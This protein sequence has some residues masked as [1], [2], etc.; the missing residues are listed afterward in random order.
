MHNSVVPDLQAIIPS[1][2]SFSCLPSIHKL[3][4]LQ[5][6]N[7]NKVID[8][9]TLI[10][11]KHVWLCKLPSSI[12]VTLIITALINLSLVNTEKI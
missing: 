1:A 12:I 2:A 11:K 8:T 9:G 4:K 7:Q 3:I 10:I 6:N 5:S